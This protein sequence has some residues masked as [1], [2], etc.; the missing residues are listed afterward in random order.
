MT[1]Q[2]ISVSMIVRNEES[3]LARCLASVAG[4]DELVVVDTGSTDASKA[5]AS[6]F[7]ARLFDF[8]WC[9]DFAAARNYSLSHCTG[10][11]ILV[12]DADWTMDVGGI[13]RARRAIAAAD[14][15]WRTINVNIET[16]DGLH[17]YHQPLLFRR[18]PEVYWKG[19]IH[20]H[21]SVTENHPSDLRFWYGYSEAHKADPDRALRILLR[22]VAKN[23]RPTREV[24]YLAREY[25]YRR[26]YAEAARLY[27]DYL[28]RGTWSPEV[29]DAWLMLARCRWYQNQGE[30]AR[31]ACLQSLKWNAQN[32][33]ACRLM[34]EMSGPK[35]A[36]RWREVAATAT[37]ADVLWVS[38]APDAAPA[39]PKPPAHYDALFAVDDLARYD[40]IRRRIAAR[41]GARR[42]LDIGCGTAPLAELIVQY[43]GFDFAPET[44]A[45]AQAA[46]RNV[47]LGDVGDPANYRDADVYLATE[48]LEHVADDA[49]VVAQIPVGR[50]V[51]LTVPSF[52]CAGHLRTYN[53]ARAIARFAPLL[54]LRALVYYV[55]RDGAWL[56]AP[57]RTEP[58]ILYIEGI[59][60]DL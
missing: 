18:C 30:K 54:D 23:P 59:R 53:E 9:D 51:I 31:D 15:A 26:N 17:S 57:E 8:T 38:R 22:E 60:R 27:E 29:A 10:D 28:T 4:A 6:G 21:L 34:A 20:N 46:G 52:A 35:N 56:E 1:T 37:D 14:P 36:A 40:A 50:E 45:R 24:Y 2:R 58:F 32:S 5:I 7:G 11:W 44:I 49:A 48:V 25:W 33:A 42:A 43:A 16:R 41:V 55:W 3:C 13:D 12:I 39:A 47:W 19:A